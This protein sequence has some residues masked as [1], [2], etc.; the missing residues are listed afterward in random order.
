MDPDRN[1]P[2]AA[3]LLWIDD[4]VTILETGG[5]ILAR[6]GFDVDFAHTGYDALTK[7]E[8]RAY[9]GVILDLGL[10]DRPGIEILHVIRERGLP[11]SVLTGFG[12]VQAAVRA[13]R[14]GIVEFRE[15]P[16]I[17]D[18]LVE[19]AVRLASA[20]DSAPRCLALESIIEHLEAALAAPFSDP[21]TSTLRV[22]LQM[23][24]SPNLS[25]VNFMIVCAAICAFGQGHST[26]SYL[27]RRITVRQGLDKATQAKLERLDD[28][29]RQA[30]IGC[31][32]EL[33]TAMGM[34]PRGLAA[35]IRT[36]T[37]ANYG[38][39]RAATRVRATLLLAATTHE[40]LDQIAY[41]T[42][43]SHPTQFTRDCRRLL[44]M[45]PTAFRR[46]SATIGQR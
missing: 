25:I 44:R 22:L 14:L 16:A 3:P 13:A 20:H 35:L 6:A 1:R 24:L 39:V 23:L 12:T 8:Q 10:P 41:R 2:L 27:H 26:L 34:S 40:H 42:G 28:L 4:D 30:S 43:Y 19:F 5:M 9:R 7:I 15:K 31:I 29:V 36:A 32:G 45:S 21:R 38:T 18:D 11:V 37:E 17:G 33:A 46:L